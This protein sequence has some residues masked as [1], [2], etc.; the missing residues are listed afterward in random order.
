M[1]QT[2]TPPSAGDSN[3]RTL[4]KGDIIQL[5]RKGYFIVDEPLLRPGKPIVLFAIPDGKEKKPL[6]QP[7]K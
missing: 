3:M 4:Q 7:A 1:P 2:V 5:E 6:Q